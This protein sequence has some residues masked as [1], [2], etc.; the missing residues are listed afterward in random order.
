MSLGKTVGKLVKVAKDNANG[1]KDIDKNF[2]EISKKLQG[3]QGDDPSVEDKMKKIGEQMKKI[4]DM[5]A[6]MSKQMGEVLKNMK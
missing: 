1:S 6:E 3:S 5:Q 4:D 2:A